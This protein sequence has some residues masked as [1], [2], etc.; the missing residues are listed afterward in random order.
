MGKRR[1]RKTFP[2]FVKDS[3]KEKWFFCSKFL[4]T[5]PQ[6]REKKVMENVRVWD[7]IVKNGQRERETDN[8][9]RWILNGYD[10]REWCKRKEK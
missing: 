5:P 7:E 9:E 1:R 4:L 10:N 3:N 2:L 6:V 8:E